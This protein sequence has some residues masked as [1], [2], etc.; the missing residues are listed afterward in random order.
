[1]IKSTNTVNIEGSV[2]DHDELQKYFSMDAGDAKTK[3]LVRPLILICGA[4]LA[5]AALFASVF[6][7]AV[8]MVIVPV[9][10]VAMWAMKPKTEARQEPATDIPDSDLDVPETGAPN[11]A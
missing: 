5:I 11:P 9:L 8:S 4:G 2:I 3:W 6:L 1:M 7:V 10:G